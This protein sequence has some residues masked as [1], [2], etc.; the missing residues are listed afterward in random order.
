[1][2]YQT[3]NPIQYPHYPTFF[4]ECILNSNFRSLTYYYMIF[5]LQRT[6]LAPKN[7]DTIHVHSSYMHEEQPMLELFVHSDMNNWAW[8]TRTEV[9]QI[10]CGHVLREFKTKLQIYSRKCPLVRIVRI[11]FFSGKE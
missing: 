5:Y 9:E 7:Q 3:L 10:C 1:M 11:P 6:C 8:S 4:K 2:N